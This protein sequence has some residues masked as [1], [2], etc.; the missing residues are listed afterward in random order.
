MLQKARRKGKGN[1]NSVETI[2]GGV[3]ITQAIEKSINLELEG[4][5]F[6]ESRRNRCSNRVS[7]IINCEIIIKIISW[8]V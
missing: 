8:T 7:Q 6:E 2:S 3:K 1:D 5:I 4:K